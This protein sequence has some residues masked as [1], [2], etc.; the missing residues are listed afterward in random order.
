MPVPILYPVSSRST[1]R[2]GLH[3]LSMILLVAWL[4][5]TVVYVLGGMWVYLRKARTHQLRK[6]VSV[7]L[8]LLFLIAMLPI[9]C[10]TEYSISLSFGPVL[11]LGLSLGACFVEE[12]L[13]WR[14]GRVFGLAGIPGLVAALTLFVGLFFTSGGIFDPAGTASLSPLMS[15]RL[16]PVLS[17]RITAGQ[18]IIGAD[19]IYRYEIYKNP[20][21]FPF[22]QRRIQSESVPLGCMDPDGIASHR[23][24]PQISLGPDAKTLHLTCAYPDS[25]IRPDTSV[26]VRLQN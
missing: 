14:E 12:I 20:P 6:R 10:L 18:S 21:R 8:L 11:I 2:R 16:S 13:V 4:G 23:I 19:T 3:S 25:E 1:P 5:L 7:V 15:G 17:Y 22:V 9:Q 26:D 24:V